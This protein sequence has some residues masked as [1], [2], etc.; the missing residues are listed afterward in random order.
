MNWKFK[1]AVSKPSID[2]LS[3]EL[4]INEVLSRLLVQRGID[5]FEKA[6]HIFTPKLEDLNDPI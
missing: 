6:K 3:K 5:T 1:T 2:S 4:K